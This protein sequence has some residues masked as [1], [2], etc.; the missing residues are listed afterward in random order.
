M[1]T[2]KRLGS[3]LDGGLCLVASVGALLGLIGCGGPTPPNPI[4]TPTAVPTP[5]PTP[6]TPPTPTPTATPSATPTPIPCTPQGADPIPNP[7]PSSAY[8]AA[9]ARGLCLTSQQSRSVDFTNRGSSNLVVS[10]A[11]LVDDVR[12]NFSIT[13]NNC[14]TVN[15]GSLFPGALCSITVL[16]QC[17]NAPATAILRVT[18]NSP[19]RSPLDVALTCNR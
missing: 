19:N 16:A 18:S 8:I 9:S 2:E 4:P 6:T 3:G 12:V 10:G 14:G 13:S 17:G 11:S 1:K 7:T 5:T 15:G